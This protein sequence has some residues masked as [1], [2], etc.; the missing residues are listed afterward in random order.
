LLFIFSF[1]PIVLSGIFAANEM[2]DI[3]TLV[4]TTGVM[5]GILI[6]AISLIDNDENRDTTKRS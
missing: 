1:P 2:N 6:I 4:Y 3:A 5:I